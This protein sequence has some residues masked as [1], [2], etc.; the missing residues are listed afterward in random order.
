MAE[1]TRVRTTPPTLGGEGEEVRRRAMLL[2]AAIAM[3]LVAASGVAWA[4]P[5]QCTGG[6]PDGWCPGTEESDVINGTGNRD[7]VWVFVGHDAVDGGGGD[8]GLDGDEGNDAL[9]GGPGQDDLYGKPGDDGLSGGAGPDVILARENEG[10]GIDSVRGGR[11]HD[12][13]DARDGQV[14]FIAC[15]RGTDAVYFDAWIDH[16]SPD[17]EVISS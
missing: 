11:G 10:T 2:L 8:D 12:Y 9:T 3:A 7:A 15:G 16:V 6:G 13:V 14:D 1:G 4:E 5:I 17:C